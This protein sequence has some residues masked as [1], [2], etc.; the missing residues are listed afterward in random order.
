MGSFLN[1][2]TIPSYSLFFLI[3]NSSSHYSS[4]FLIFPHRSYFFVIVSYCSSLFLSF[5][6]GSSLFLIFLHGSSLFL[7]FLHG[8]SLFL[9]IPHL[10]LCILHFSLLVAAQ[11][12]QLY[13]DLASA[14]ESGWDFSSRWF[15]DGKTLETIH[16]SDI[17]PVDL[18]VYL[19]RNEAMM[20]EFYHLLG[21]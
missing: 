20:A 19:Q 9:H 2:L 11:K 21:E 6:H 16:T 3:V 4:L 17:I 18:N 7:I 14:A 15:R 1:S 8:S 13:S 12:S 5:L 10:F